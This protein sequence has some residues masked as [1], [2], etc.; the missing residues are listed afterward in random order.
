[1]LLLKVKDFATGEVI[2]E[3]GLSHMAVQDTQL[4][5]FLEETTYE[6]VPFSRGALYKVEVESDDPGWIVAEQPGE[7]VIRQF[8]VSSWTQDGETKEGVTN[9]SVAFR[10][11]G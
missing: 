4:S 6:A 9:N 10:L 3:R 1:M 11:F 2:W 5:C 7:F 8:N